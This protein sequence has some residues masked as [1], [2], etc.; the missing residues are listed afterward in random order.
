MYS[1]DSGVEITEV[2]F[3]LEL[4]LISSETL[5]IELSNDTSSE[6]VELTDI[7]L[8]ISEVPEIDVD[9]AQVW[10]EVGVSH[11]SSSSPSESSFSQ[12]SEVG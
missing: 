9:S 4:D 11:S 7:E 2:S 1:V 3:I 12:S 8:I 10:Q 5:A 6:I